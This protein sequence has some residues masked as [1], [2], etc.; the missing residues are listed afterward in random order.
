M[1]R[2]HYEQYCDRIE[3]LGMQMLDLVAELRADPPDFCTRCSRVPILD[4]ND[5]LRSRR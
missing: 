1:T 3:D 4:A 2:Y 5:L